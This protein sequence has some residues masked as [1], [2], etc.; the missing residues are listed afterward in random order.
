MAKSRAHRSA[1]FREFYV[2]DQ[3]YVPFNYLKY[4]RSAIE[5]ANEKDVT[6]QEMQ[7]LL[8]T[9]D[10]EFWTIRHV[11]KYFGWTYGTSKNIMMSIA[12]KGLI[13][14]QFDRLTPSQKRVDHLFRDETKTNYRVRYSLSEKGRKMVN[15]FYKIANQNYVR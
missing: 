2:L 6:F 13:Y 1:L 7:L 12:R 5:Y 8:Y 10:L 9:Y 11:R 3:K 15:S 4:I 14:K